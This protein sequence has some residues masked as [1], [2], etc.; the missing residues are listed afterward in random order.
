V[1]L[2]KQD[3][4]ASRRSIFRVGFK[5]NGFEKLHGRQ[6]LHLSFTE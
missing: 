4:A 6:A 3:N 5:E 2:V 1:G